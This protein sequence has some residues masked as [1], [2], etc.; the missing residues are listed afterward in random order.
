M[1][2]SE[3][4]R[5]VPSL[6]L[7][8]V[9]VA[10]SDSDDTDHTVLTHAICELVNVTNVLLSEQCTGGGLTLSKEEFLETNH[11]HGSYT[12]SSQYLVHLTQPGLTACPLTCWKISVCGAASI[13]RTRR[14]TKRCTRP[15][16]WRTR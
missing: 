12:T 4:R 1:T 15:E 16:R 10:G 2:S 3:H 14:T 8:V 6:P 5:A 7:A 9:G 13:S 11:I